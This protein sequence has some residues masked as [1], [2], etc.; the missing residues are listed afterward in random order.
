MARDYDARIGRYLESDP[1]GIDA[2][3]NT[4][5]YAIGN[6]LSF[7]DPTGESALKIIKLCKDGYNVV[8]EVGFKE[9]VRAIRRGE[10]VL[11]SRSQQAKQVADAAGKGAG[12]PIKDPA[13]GGDGYK[14]HYHTFDRKG[15]HVFYGIAA[16][17]TF[18]SYFEGCDC[19]MG[20]AAPILDFFN[21]FSLPYDLLELTGN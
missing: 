21:P 11:A 6:P 8:R 20:R 19:A 10:N 13:H 9:A 17:L 1:I 12:K 3:L 7:I 14:P 2:G 18:S 5:T 16:A 15:G 4:F